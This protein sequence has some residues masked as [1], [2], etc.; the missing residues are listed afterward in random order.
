MDSEEKFQNWTNIF[1]DA[2]FGAPTELGIRMQSQH[3]PVYA[4]HYSYKGQFSLTD[5]L[6][7]IS[8]KYPVILEYLYYRVHKLLEE[9]LFGI[10]S[11]HY[12]RSCTTIISVGN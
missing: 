3:A 5:L 9:K 6:L 8:K 11:H 12:G 7:A 4:Y 1:T 10:P 2:G